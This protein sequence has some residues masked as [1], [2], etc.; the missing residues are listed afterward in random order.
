MP[1][2]PEFPEIMLGNSKMIA[3]KRLDLLRTRLE[4]GPT[5]KALNSDFLNKYEP[6]LHMEEGKEDTYLDAG[7]YL[8]HHCILRPDN[9]TTKLRVVF[10]AISETNSG[11][12]LKELLYKGG[13]L[14]EDLFSILIRFRKHIYA[15]T[16]DIKQMFRMIELNE[17][18]SRLQKILWENSK[19]SPT[20]VYELQ[21]VTYGT[22]SAPC[23]AT[24]VLQQ[25]ALDEEKNSPLASKVLLQDF[26]MHDCLSGSSESTEFET[27]HLELKQRLQRGGMTLHKWCSSYSPT[28]AQEFPLDRNSEEVQVKTLGM[29]WNN[30]SDTFTY[31]TNVNINQSYT[32]RYVLS[33]IARIYDPVRLLGPVISKAK[34]FMQQLWLLKL[35]WYEILP[36]DI[37][38]QWDNFIKTL[39]DLE[40][41]KIRRCFLQTNAIR[42]ILQGFAEASSKGY[43][44]LFIFK[45]CPSTRNQTADFFEA[46]HESH[47]PRS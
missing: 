20:K 28:I 33:Q 40:K 11:Y 36:P 29:I 1:L 41:I 38:Q 35:D 39:P 13:V 46:S 22:A 15:F 21:T 10:K 24:K 16:A 3:S 37:S 19:P 17:S 34:I 27:I 43:G 2:K 30:V 23:L 14:Q 5:M 44:L 25:L 26:Y 9:K 42:V 12:S 31:K 7:Y 4:R 6:L 32:K 18:Q 8:P 45:Q 47:Q